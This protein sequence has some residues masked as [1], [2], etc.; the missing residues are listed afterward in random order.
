MGELNRTEF[1]EMVRSG[2][3]QFGGDEEFMK[4]VIAKHIKEKKKLQKLIKKEVEI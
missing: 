2:Y 3:I 4:R 1:N